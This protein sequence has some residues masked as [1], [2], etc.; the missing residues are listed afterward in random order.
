MWTLKYY[1]N[2]IR[3]LFFN[4]TDIIDILSPSGTFKEERTLSR[5]LTVFL[6]RPFWISHAFHRQCSSG[7]SSVFY[8]FL[9]KPTK[10]ISFYRIFLGFFFSNQF[11]PTDQIPSGTLVQTFLNCVSPIYN[12][13]GLGS[14][15]LNWPISADLKASA[16]AISLEA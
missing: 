1:E 2:H 14:F 10:G 12:L 16:C 9:V 7:N 13:S 11:P 8:F 6:S 4:D 15:C 3:W 5:T